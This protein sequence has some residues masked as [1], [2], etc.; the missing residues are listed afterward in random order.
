LGILQADTLDRHAQKW[1]YD[2]SMRSIKNMKKIL[3][4]TA[5][6]TT[7]VKKSPR[8]GIF[9]DQTGVNVIEFL[10]IAAILVVLALLIVPNLNLFLGTDSKIAAANTEA[11]NVRAAALAYETN[12]GKYPSNSDVL[13]NEPP[14][15][16][17]YIGQ[18]G[19]YYTFDIG[20][21]RILDATT[22]TQEHIPVKPWTGIRWDYTSGSWVK[23]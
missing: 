17:D 2:N 4:T 20:T 13:W 3:V 10:L 7:G 1:Y 12:N 9:S 22:D 6:T 5:S 18:P 16:G 8:T 23:E 15:P 21:G 14:K 11:L 19:A